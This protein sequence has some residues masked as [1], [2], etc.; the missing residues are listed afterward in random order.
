MEELIFEFKE[1][2][3]FN[4]MYGYGN[5]RFYFHEKFKLTC[6]FTS[7]GFD[8]DTD[9]ELQ[10]HEYEINE[11]GFEII[12]I[13]FERTSEFIENLEKENNN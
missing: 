13:W 8:E 11:N 2:E 3:Y 12:K 7:Y 1:C 5:V 4:S 6:C 9:D 10:E